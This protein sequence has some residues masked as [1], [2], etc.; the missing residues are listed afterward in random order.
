[1]AYF[2]GEIQT[3]NNCEMNSIHWA[4][5]NTAEGVQERSA[6]ASDEQPASAARP[7]QQKSIQDTQK[8]SQKENGK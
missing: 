8:W 4:A 5:G 7:K 6:T 3:I 1:M 2:D